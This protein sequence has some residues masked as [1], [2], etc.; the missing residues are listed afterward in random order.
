MIGALTKNHQDYIAWPFLISAT[1]KK[2][3]AEQHTNLLQLARR[4]CN[5]NESLMGSH[6][7]CLTSDGESQ[8]GKALVALTEKL[9]LPISSP[10]HLFIH[11]LTFLNTM[12]GDQ[13]ITSNKDYK[14]IMK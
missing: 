14:H 13:D 10:I 7:Y 2:E 1:C 11:N 12:V 3:N 8:C 5:E 4:V 6:V 9:P